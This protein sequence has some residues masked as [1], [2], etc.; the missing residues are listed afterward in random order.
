M[1][2][3][4]GSSDHRTNFTCYTD[5]VVLLDESENDLQRLCIDSKW[6]QRRTVWEC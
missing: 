6:R 4:I 3:R 2:T 5:Y 1:D